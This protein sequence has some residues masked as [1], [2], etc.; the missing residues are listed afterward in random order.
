M[1]PDFQGGYCQTFDERQ[2]AVHW[3][4]IAVLQRSSPPSETDAAALMQPESV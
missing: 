3:Q 4:G 2:W 1:Q